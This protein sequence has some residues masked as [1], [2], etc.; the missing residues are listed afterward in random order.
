MRWLAFA[1]LA[2]FIIG[3]QTGM[4]EAMNFHQSG[5]NFVLMA[6]VFIAMNAP[7]D[8]GLLGGFILGAL[9]DL[10]SGGTMGLYALSYGL[11]AMFVSNAKQVVYREHFLTHFSLTL[12]G[13]LLCGAVL[14]IHGWIK[15]P[16]VSLMPLI[17]TAIYSAIL[18][19]IVIGI[20]QRLKLVFHFQ[21]ARAARWPGLST[22]R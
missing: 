19:I 15:G 1:I 14:F 18:A 17:Y 9:Q 7:R 6:V 12:G 16:H 4:A 11:V 10:T 22:R 8:A 21:S 20:L 5:P 2:Y 13:G 3:M